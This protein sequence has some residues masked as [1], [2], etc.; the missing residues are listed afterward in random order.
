MVV[1]ISGIEWICLKVKSFPGNEKY[2][3]E[4]NYEKYHSSSKYW[5]SKWSKRSK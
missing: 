5:K 4:N 2:F 1:K 3:K